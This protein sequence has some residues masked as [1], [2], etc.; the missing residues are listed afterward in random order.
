MSIAAPQSSDVRVISTV[1]RGRDLRPRMRIIRTIGDLIDN[2]IT[3]TGLCRTCVRGFDVGLHALA[4]VLG[5]DYVHTE[6]PLPIKCERCGG[7]DVMRV[8]GR[9]S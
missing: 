1:A 5:R 8:F 3:L 4:D 7:S 2:G 9:R 6:R